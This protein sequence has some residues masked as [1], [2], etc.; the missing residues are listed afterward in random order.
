MSGI[1]SFDVHPFGFY[2]VVAYS[3]NIKIYSIEH[4][5]MTLLYST[6]LQ[7]LRKILY[8]PDGSNL[9]IFSSRKLKILDSFSFEVK[10]ELNEKN[11]SIIDICFGSTKNILLILY[12]NGVI[13]ER[14]FYELD[15]CKIFR[16]YSHAQRRMLSLRLD[17]KNE[18]A[19][20]IFDDG[21]MLIKNISSLSCT[22]MSVFY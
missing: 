8:S 16:V 15:K 5:S 13:V 22:E 9:L 18:N 4:S 21:T 3:F 11:S 10:Y 14:S 12:D 17:E 20:I 1:L 2:M 7:H 19:F 6:S